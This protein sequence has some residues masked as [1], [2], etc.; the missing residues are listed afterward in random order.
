MAVLIA[1]SSARSL[2][3]RSSSTTSRSGR[4]ARPRRAR[5]PERRRQD[6]AAADPRRGDRDARRR[7][8]LREGRRGSRCTTSALRLEQACRC[9]STS[10]PGAPTSSRSRRSCARSSRRWR[11]ETTTRR[12]SP[13]RGGPASPRARGRLRT[14]ATARRPSCAAS[15]SPKTTSTGRCRTFSGGELT[16][17]SLAR[18]LGGD[19]DLLLLDEPTNHLDVEPRVARAELEHARRRRDPR[20]PRPLVPRGRDDRALEIENGKPMFFPGPW[21]NWR[22]EKAARAQHARRRPRAQAEDIAR[23]ERFV[24][25]F[26]YKASRRSRRRRS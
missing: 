25:R 4:A 24:E 9:A 10:S 2:P 5:R 11:A 3:A 7:A 15:A 17:A 21:H 18:A 6:D 20:R 22:R 12:R 8:G 19:P 16:R 1:S 13:L 14:G 26:R 23:L